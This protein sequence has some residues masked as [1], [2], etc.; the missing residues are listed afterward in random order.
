MGIC[1]SASK[2]GANAGMC[3]HPVSLL[4]T[5]LE[6]LTTSPA[7]DTVHHHEVPLTV[8]EETPPTAAIGRGG[9]HP[10]PLPPHDEASKGKGYKGVPKGGR[11]QERW[12]TIPPSHIFSQ[13][14][15]LYFVPASHKKRN[16]LSK[17]PKE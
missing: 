7:R 17:Y 6:A 10:R 16:P 14:G 2:E 12:S 8:D 3:S 15:V 9:H 11:G 5:P 1:V 13:L 4:P